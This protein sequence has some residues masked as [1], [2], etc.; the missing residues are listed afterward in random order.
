M[1]R[2]IELIQKT[3]NE[4]IQYHLEEFCQCA[5]ELVNTMFE[6]FPQIIA[7][8]SDERLSDIAEDATYWPAQLEKIVNVLEKGDEFAIVDALYNETLPNLVELKN[9]LIEREIV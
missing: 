5:G 8:Y 9:I 3:V 4:L 2:V 1:D 7:T 6:V